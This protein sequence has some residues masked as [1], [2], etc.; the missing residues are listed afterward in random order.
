MLFST[1]MQALI[2]THS[3]HSA[4]QPTDHRMK[5]CSPHLYS[6][7]ASSVADEGRK[8]IKNTAQK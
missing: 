5:P 8:E 4:E 1:H 6:S 2:S 7:V 3:F